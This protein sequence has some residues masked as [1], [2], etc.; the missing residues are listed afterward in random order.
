MRRRRALVL[1]LVAAAAVLA[2]S[3]PCSVAASSAGDAAVGSGA[4]LPHGPAAAALVESGAEVELDAARNR[5]GFLSSIKKAVSKAKS[6]VHHVKA[7]A[8]QVWGHVK[9]AASRVVGH[10][11][12]AVGHVKNAFHSVKNAFHGAVSAVARVFKPKANGVPV[13]AVAV[14]P[15][16][17]VMDWKTVANAP[18]AASSPVPWTGTPLEVGKSTPTSSVDKPTTFPP[19]E[20]APAAPGAE[21]PKPVEAV[22]DYFQLLKL[23]IDSMTGAA[24]RDALRRQAAVISINQDPKDFVDLAEKGQTPAFTRQVLGPSAPEAREEE[25]IAAAIASGEMTAPVDNVHTRYVREDEVDN[26]ELDERAT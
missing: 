8:T 24:T 10:F 26:P 20:K 2:L 19:D 4:A 12:N 15:G 1:V 5:V 3:L 18:G 14:G 16:L 22:P 25:R 7:K 9:S 21:A 23:R 17:A 6:V 11:K 13:G